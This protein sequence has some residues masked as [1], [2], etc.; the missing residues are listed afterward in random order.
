LRDSVFPQATRFL[1][2]SDFASSPASLLA[3]SIPS[4]F[5]D[6]YNCF[7]SFSDSAENKY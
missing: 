3:A 4:F 5:N 6:P 2:S 7:F 1:P